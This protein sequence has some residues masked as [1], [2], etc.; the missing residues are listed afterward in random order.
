M[1][2][3]YVYILQC[4][5]GAYYTGITNDLD[6]RVNEH[7]EGLDKKAYTYRKRPVSLVYREIFN[8]VLHAI[9]WEKRIKGW[10]R[11]KK[12]AVISGEWNVLPELSEC[13]NWSSHQIYHHLKDVEE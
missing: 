3:Y 2:F 9:A 4:A 5:D 1:K 7:N 10:S 12:E 11:A 6:R 13:K 8:E